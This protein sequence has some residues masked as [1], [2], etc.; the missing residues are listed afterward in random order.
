MIEKKVRDFKLSTHHAQENQN[1]YMSL[2]EELGGFITFW[3][4]ML[5]GIMIVLGLIGYTYTSFTINT[6]KIK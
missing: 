4:L 5:S 1:N 3:F 6:Y 2:K